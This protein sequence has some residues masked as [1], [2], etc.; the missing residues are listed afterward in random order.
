MTTASITPG[1]LSDWALEVAAYTDG[2]EPTDYVSVRGITEFTPP[3]AEKNLEDDGDYDG[4][5]WGS[6]IATGLSYTLEGTYKLPR[7]GYPS[8]PGQ[9]IIRTAGQGALEAGFVHWRAYN[10]ISGAGKKGLADASTSA[11]GGPKTD[12]QTE[13]FTLTGR[14]GLEDYTSTVPANLN[15][16]ATAL[17]TGSAITGVQVTNGGTGYTVAPTVVFTGGGGT[18]AVATASVAGGKVVDVDVTNGGTGYTSAPAVSFTR[19]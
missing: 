7:G 14:G 1:K 15:A 10:K 2:T 12:L 18:G 19:N 16:T 3:V 8:D 5:E 9:E 4:D 6:Q 13:G 11:N 17:R